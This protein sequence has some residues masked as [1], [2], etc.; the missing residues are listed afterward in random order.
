MD[1]SLSESYLLV[2][3]ELDVTIS[4]TKTHKGNTLFEFAKRFGY[5]NSEITQFPI[6]GLL[7]C[8]GIYSLVTQVLESARERGFLPLFIQSASTDF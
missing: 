6:T 8:K 3:T 7:E 2:M 4:P 5:K 1:K